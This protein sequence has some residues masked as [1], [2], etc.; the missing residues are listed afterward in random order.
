MYV[1]YDP[2][3]YPKPEPPPALMRAIDLASWL[4][5]VTSA[6]VSVGAGL[7]ALAHADQAAAVAG[8]IA[9]VAGAFGVLATG[10]GARVRDE[11]LERAA[12]VG[13]LGVQMSD[14]ALSQI[15]GL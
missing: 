7:A 13:N 11:R 8:I 3:I 14:R 9:G 5:P 1:G 12:A 15:P 2:L 4:L 6:V 10:W